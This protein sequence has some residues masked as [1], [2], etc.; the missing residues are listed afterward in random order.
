MSRSDEWANASWPR[1]LA[2]TDMDGPCICPGDP[3]HAQH[4]DPCGAPNSG[5][6]HGP[7]CRPCNTARFQRINAGFAE[8]RA[9]LAGSTPDTVVWEETP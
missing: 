9:T 6:G 8:I 4:P 7:W 3:D 1:L 5:T 2:L